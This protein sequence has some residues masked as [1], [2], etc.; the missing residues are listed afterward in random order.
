MAKEKFEESPAPVFQSPRPMC[1]QQV[2]AT[3]TTPVPSIPGTPTA[4]ALLLQQLKF[5][6]PSSISSESLTSSNSS[7]LMPQLR[8]LNWAGDVA[9]HIK[10]H[11][12]LCMMTFPLVHPNLILT[13]TLKLRKRTKMA[14]Q[15]TD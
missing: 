9:V 6:T 13:S 4:L 11:N 2:A 7:Q 15:K 8:E 14:V 1:Q 5:G 12:P 3:P 10:H